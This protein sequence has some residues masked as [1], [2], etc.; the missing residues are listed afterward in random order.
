[1][2]KL[3]PILLMVLLVV[4]GCG[5]EGGPTNNSQPAAN[6][7]EQD[8]EKE[9][10]QTNSE[11][12]SRLE[13]LKQSFEDAGFKVG[14]NEI[15]AFEMMHASNGLKFKLDDE[16]IEIYEYDLDN[17]TD[18]AKNIVNQAKEGSVEFSGFNVPVVYKGGLI[19]V[20]HDEHSQGEKIKE[21]F[22]NYK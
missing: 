12:K 17:L 14:E 2:K 7:V 11:A 19:L 3:I 4:S 5:K 13:G 15:L 9:V 6:Q 10:E 1:M 8:Q 18:E 22:N 20:R 21:I 16:L